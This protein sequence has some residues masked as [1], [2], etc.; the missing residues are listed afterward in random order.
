MII[1]LECLE[2]DILWGSGAVPRGAERRAV[3]GGVVGR[4]EEV[5]R[6]ETPTVE[7]R[8]E[9]VN[10]RKVEENNVMVSSLCVG[11][12]KREERSGGGRCFYMCLSG[13]YID[14]CYARK[15]EGT[16]ELV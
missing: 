4:K 11:W 12:L 10:R 2:D 3:G 9:V 16:I 8:G 1:T 7:R 15:T 13:L 5:A 6:R 14:S